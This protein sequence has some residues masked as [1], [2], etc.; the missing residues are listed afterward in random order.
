MRNRSSEAK[1]PSEQR[2]STAAKPPRE[3]RRTATGAATTDARVWPTDSAPSSL[4]RSPGP[5]TPTRKTVQTTSRADTDTSETRTPSS[6]H[7]PRAAAPPSGAGTRERRA[8]AASAT[9][10]TVSSACMARWGPSFVTQVPRQQV[11]SVKKMAPIIARRP[12]ADWGLIRTCS[13]SKAASPMAGAFMYLPIW[14]AA[15][16]RM[17]G[18]TAGRASVLP[19]VSPSLRESMAAGAGS[20]PVGGARPGPSVPRRLPR[21]AA[22]TPAAV[23][24]AT[25]S[26]S[27]ETALPCPS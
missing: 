10:A 1:L 22:G 25:R 26:A 2:P 6:S 24:P 23:A 4:P 8:A 5:T 12:A 16:K 11:Q 20:G 27:H 15:S 3:Y 21:T 7:A 9:A 14:R 17:M 18:P 13:S 19:T